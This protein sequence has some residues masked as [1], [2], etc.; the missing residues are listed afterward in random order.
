MNR[1]KIIPFVFGVLLSTTITA[2]KIATIEVELTSSTNGIDVP[3]K[4]DLNALTFL[5][6]STLNLVAI[7]GN[8]RT[9]VPF[10]IESGETRLL[11]WIVKP[12]TAAAKKYSYE[13][14]KGTPGKFEAVNATMDDGALTIQAGNKNLLR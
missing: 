1:K 14:V 3:V 2:Q 7:E 8:R 13:L 11:H 9:P 10:Q 12:G 5:H 6:D 4:T